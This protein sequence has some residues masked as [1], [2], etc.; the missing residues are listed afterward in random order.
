MGQLETEGARAIETTHPSTARRADRDQLGRIFRVRS[1]VIALFAI[2]IPLIPDLGDS[3]WT[4]VAAIVLVVLPYNLVLER[5]TMRTGIVPSFVPWADQVLSVGATVFVPEL[6][7]PVLMVMVANSAVAATSFERRKV[8]GPAL[9]SIVVAGTVGA[10]TQPGVMAITGTVAYA[11]AT[12]MAIL[13]ISLV[14]ST[15]LTLESENQELVDNIDAM[16]WSLVDGDPSYRSMSGPASRILDYPMVRLLDVGFWHDQIHPDDRPVVDGV[17]R[18]ALNRGITVDVDYRIKSGDGSWISVHEIVTGE[19]GTP[20]S[21]AILR[22][23]TLDV[24]ARRTAERDRAVYGEMVERITTALVVAGPSE[25]G[26]GLRI[27]AANPAAA[28]MFGTTS[29]RLTGAALDDVF[30]TLDDTTLARISDANDRT[31][32]FTIDRVEGLGIDRQKTFSLQVFALPDGAVG[33]AMDDVTEAAMVAAALRRQALHDGLTGLPN[34]TLLRDRLQYALAD[35]T[36]RKESVALILLDLNH[37]KDVNDALG[38]QYGDRL[39]V[40]FARRLQTLLRECDTIARLGGDEFALLLT[41]ATNEGASRVVAKVTSAMQQPFEL[42]GVTVQATAS[43]GVALFPDHATDGDLLTQRADVAMYNAKRGGG[44]WSVYSPAQDQSSVERLTLL[45]ALHS[46]LEGDLPTQLTLHYQPILDLHTD[47]IAGAEALLRWNHPTMGW[48][49]PELVVELAELSGLIQPLARFVV[50][51]ALVTAGSWLA[52]GHELRIAVNLSA[53]NL[54]DRNLVAWLD[55]TMR[56]M[57]FP[58]RLLKCEL[59]ESQ[60]MDDPVLAMDVISQLRQIGVTTAI[61]DFGTGYS[62]LAYLR[63]LPVDEIKIDKSFVQTMLDDHN[64]LTI[65][66]TVVDLAHN[67]GMNVLAEGVEDAKTLETLRDFG[68]DRVQG[69]LIGRPMTAEDF[70]ASLE[71]DVAA[72]GS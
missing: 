45:S 9:A 14:T 58:S 72:S 24:T 7:E 3:R 54:Y 11:G 26:D 22:G 16:V 23:I 2:A 51:E 33:L 5:R 59:T 67:L 8:F 12:A 13:T 18:R 17:R 36:R 41:H 62:S 68:C 60:V 57:E 35:A 53:R 66:R 34:R 29:T 21:P 69:Y 47:T 44:G 15:R 65:V 43:L 4:T 37:F 19:A 49:D 10:A 61:D 52:R 64:D 55:D 6:W 38:H 25:S 32:G 56:S 63:R 30:D 40:A 39:L 42:D 70:R 50:T 48:L 71:G 28:R 31:A 20:V 46:E 1:R 27:R